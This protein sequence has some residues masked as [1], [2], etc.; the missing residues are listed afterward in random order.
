M[1][2]K[3]KDIYSLSSLD[4]AES[5]EDDW[6]FTFDVYLSSLCSL[7]VHRVKILEVIQ[8]LVLS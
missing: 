1:K 6:L 4:D 2:R 7:A 3:N 8:I 5:I